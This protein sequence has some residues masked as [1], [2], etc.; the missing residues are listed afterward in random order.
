[1]FT[2][3]IQHQGEIK[4]IVKEGDWVFT[5]ESKDIIPTLKIG[6]SVACSGVCLTVIR[7]TD[8]SFDV[9][10]STETLSKTTLAGWQEG[11][12]IN[13]ES[14]LLMGDD[15]GGHMVSGHVDGVARLL[16]NDPENDSLRLVFE[17]PDEFA[18]Y[19]A[20]K[21]S[22]ALDGISLTVNDV[23]GPRFGVNIIPHTQNV[24][25]LSMAK[26]GDFLNFEID[27]IARYVGRILANRGIV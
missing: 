4:R 12:K 14:S 5:I 27:M 8:H 15:I 26:P 23:I 22:I 6:S 3:I 10:V 18:S 1:M 9:Q 11:Q 20:P 16:S 24:T 25:T 13:L 2:G 19:L 21:G 7:M 17:L